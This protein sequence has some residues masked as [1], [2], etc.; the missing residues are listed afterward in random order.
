[1]RVRAIDDANLP[2]TWT[3]YDT[4]TTAKDNVA[5]AQPSIT[6]ES[7]RPGMRIIVTE[8]D[9]DDWDKIKYFARYNADPG[10]ASA[11]LVHTGRTTS[12]THTVGNDYY[13]YWY[14]RTQVVDTSGN[15][16]SASNP[17]SVHPGKLQSA[18][19]DDGSVV[20]SSIANSNITSILIAAGVINSSHMGT[21]SANC[22]VTGTIDAS[23]VGVT[24]LNA[25]NITAGTI[26]SCVVNADA[27]TVGTLSVDAS[28]ITFHGYGGEVTVT[29]GSTVVPFLSVAG[30]V[31]ASHL[32][33]AEIGDSCS[34]QG[35]LISSFNADQVDG[36]D[37]AGTAVISGWGQGTFTVMLA[38]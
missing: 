25:N 19:Y 23:T 1:M 14:A 22:I 28:S 24:S 15:I 35:G 3:A 7:A 6:V 4:G 11:Y 13:Y 18:D 17:G 26:S 31:N 8:P 37:C 16:S 30:A 33:N 5:P 27:I 12:Y 34:G 20:T 38:S 21:I 10:T 29:A 32:F 9:E 2:S 36:I